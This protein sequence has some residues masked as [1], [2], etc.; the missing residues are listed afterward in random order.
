M[1][2]YYSILGIAHTAEEVVIRAAWKA[3]AQRYHPDRFDGDS[4]QANAQMA[5]IN[6]AYNV[7][8]I[9]ASREFYDNTIANRNEAFTQPMRDD[10]PQQTPIRPDQFEQNWVKAVGSHS[11]FGNHPEIITFA[12]QLLF[13]G[14][15]AAAKELNNSIREL[16]EK[17]PPDWIINRICEDFNIETKGMWKRRQQREAKAREDVIWEKMREK[18]RLAVA[19]EAAMEPAAEQHVAAPEQFPPS[20]VFSPDPAFPSRDPISFNFQWL[21]SFFAAAGIVVLFVIATIWLLA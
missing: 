13:E 5:E 4:T 21:N 3:M 11:N 9:P 12:R 8:S 2:D 17:V 15:L 16:S 1:K 7:L 14:N 18:A 20:P 10:N 6:E 19:K